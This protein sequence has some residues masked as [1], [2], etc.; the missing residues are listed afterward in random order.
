MRRSLLLWMLAIA[1]AAY[2]TGYQI[3]RQQAIREVA[4]DRAVPRVDDDDAVVGLAIPQGRVLARC[5][6]QPELDAIAAN[7]AAHR[8][9][10]RDNEPFWVHDQ[11]GYVLA[12]CEPDPLTVTC[13]NCGSGGPTVLDEV[14]R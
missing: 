1:L 6:S 2:G 14:G 4:P 7:V 8:A 9:A 3:G 5:L 10:H 11:G 12:K 13:A